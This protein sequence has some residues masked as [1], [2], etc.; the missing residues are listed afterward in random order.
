M[1]MPE[2]VHPW[3]LPMA[4]ADRV[5]LATVVPPPAAESVVT[6][7]AAPV[8][9]A[10][11]AA[12][13]VSAAIALADAFSDAAL[14]HR[15]SGW[16]DVAASDAALAATIGAGAGAVVPSVAIRADGAPR[17]MI[18]TTDADAAVRAIEQEHGDHGVD[19]EL[20]LFLDEALRDGDQYV[21]A[22]PG[23]GFAALS[24]A[25]GD[26]AINVIA[27]CDDAAQAAAITASA[28]WSGVG[29]QVAASAAVA[30][31]Q[32]TLTA[33]SA[34]AS[35]IVHVGS[36][37]AVAPLLR[38]VLGA[39]ERREIGVVAWRC[40]RADDTGR[41]AENLQVAAAVLG[42]FGFQHFALADGEHGVELVPAEVMASNEMIF[43]IEPS[44]LARFAA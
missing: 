44:F 29:A 11:F 19:A 22:A 41:D 20:R 26:V 2:I 4:S 15:A 16:R 13:F 7:N 3:S 40:G 39:L 25:T 17:F 28:H 38:T 14:T 6:A 18:T 27:L 5:S 36:A 34:A 37:G 9:E 33:S 42:V 24:A 30:L 21:D 10:L 31:D 43:S 8:A 12:G 32:V 1:S 35:T 23:D